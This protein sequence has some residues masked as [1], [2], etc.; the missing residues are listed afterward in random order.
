MG[1]S[2]DMRMKLIVCQDAGNSTKHAQQIAAARLAQMQDDLKRT[3]KTQ[4]ATISKV[5]SYKALLDAETTQNKQ[6]AQEQTYLRTKFIALE[7]SCQGILK[8]MNER[9]TEN[10]SQ[11]KQ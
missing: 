5:D 7:A 2:E 1:N 6:L 10:E 9:I 8:S 3:D 11:L 4:A